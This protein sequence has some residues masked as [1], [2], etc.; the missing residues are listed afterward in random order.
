MFDP[1][2]S[3]EYKRIPNRTVRALN[4]YGKNGIVPGGFL[5][6]VLKNDLFSA[7]GRADSENQKALVYICRYIY[8]EL[9]H[10]CWGNENRV[11][12]WIK[13]CNH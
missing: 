13:R 7:V 5:T 10:D 4:R 9:P 3:P 11:T 1:S 8:N 6:A 12:S 2:A